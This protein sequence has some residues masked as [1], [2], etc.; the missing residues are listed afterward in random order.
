MVTAIVLNLTTALALAGLSVPFLPLDYRTRLW[1]L[2]LPVPLLLVVLHPRVLWALLARVPRLRL[3]AGQPEPPTLQTM[4][5]AIGW[6]AIGW[7][8]YGLHIAVLAEVFHVR[9]PLTLLVVSIGG[10]AL[11]WC[12][13]LVVFLLPAGAGARDLALVGALAA[14]VPAGP[15]LAVAVISR[16][17]TTVCD[18]GCAGIAFASSFTVIATAHHS[19]LRT[20]ADRADSRKMPVPSTP[21]VAAQQMRG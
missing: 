5:K 7:V 14:V 10:Y 18:L 16:L 11:A 15:A 4:V 21:T 13:G 19:R 20:S 2:T 3:V 1:W 6:C 9:N 12:A 8:S 17:V